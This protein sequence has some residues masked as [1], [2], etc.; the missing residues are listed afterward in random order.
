M[1]SKIN[2][3]FLVVF[4]FLL[5][6]TNGQTS[7]P[8]IKTDS[9]TIVL[10]S[11]L[12][13][14]TI[15]VKYI[16]TIPSSFLKGDAWY[17]KQWHA[18]NGDSIFNINSDYK[19]YY[20]DR[21]NGYSLYIDL[22]AQI[23]NTPI[24]TI[25]ELRFVSPNKDLLFYIILGLLLIYGIINNLFP[26][27]YLK[28][29]SQFSRSSLRELQNRE[30]LVQNSYASLVSN[31][32][33]ILS[34]SLLAT[35]LVF[36][37]HL[38][39][40]SFWLAY[41]YSC[42]FFTVIYIGKYI[43]LQLMGYIFNVRELVSTY[44]FVVFMINKVLGILLLPFIL[45]LAFSKPIYYSIA[46]GGAAILTILLFL[47]RYLFTLTSVRNKLHIS[48]FHFFLYLCAFEIIPL[49][50]LYKFIVQYFGGSF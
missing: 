34:F 22:S 50:I 31:I 18:K 42:L 46:I 25:I 43:S 15:I 7:S 1:M 49:L 41:L 10:D 32:G 40:I 14:D 8:S 28:L 21:K 27:Y 29:F 33:F 16:P 23:I 20:A 12:P 5:L 17:F 35:L 19:K 3:V 48:S 38:L 9:T 39:P 30:Q 11:L 26:Q 47:Y 24:N 4:S 44:I 36:N 13:K 45:M 2:A 37:S 6:S